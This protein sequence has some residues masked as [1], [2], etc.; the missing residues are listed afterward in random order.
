[1][2]LEEIVFFYESFEE[3]LQYDSW[4]FGKITARKSSW[5]YLIPL[6]YSCL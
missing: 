1:M 4:M 3:Q 5:L 6:D 2:S